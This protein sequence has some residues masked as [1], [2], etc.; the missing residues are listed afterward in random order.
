[1]NVQ[2]NQEEGVQIYSQ[3]EYKQ[4]NENTFVLLLTRNSTKLYEKKNQ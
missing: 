3:C 2:Y 1:M 4:Y